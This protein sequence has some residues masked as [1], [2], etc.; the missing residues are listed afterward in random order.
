MASHSNFFYNIDY[1]KSPFLF[2]FSSKEYV[3]TK[4]GFLTSLWVYAI[5]LYFFFNSNMIMRRNPEIQDLLLANPSPL[6]SL[7]NQNFAPVIIIKNQ[8]LVPIIID[9]SY[10]TIKITQN[11][12][13]SSDGSLTEDLRIIHLC[14]NNDFNDNVPEYYYKGGYCFNSSLKISTLESDSEYLSIKLNLCDNVTSSKICQPLENIQN[15]LDGC[16]FYFFFY[17]NNFD[18]SDFLNPGKFNVQNI[19]QFIVNKDFIQY[20]IYGLMEVDLLENN[21]YFYD[22]E[23]KTKYF[24]QDASQFASEF[25]YYSE[26]KAHTLIALD[27]YPSFTKRVIVRRYQKF[28]ELLSSIGGL[29]SVLHIFGSLFVNFLKKITLLEGI[30]NNNYQIKEKNE[31]NELNKS[32]LNDFPLNINRYLNK[33]KHVNKKNLF[34]KSYFSENQDNIKEFEFELPKIEIVSSE[35]K[36]IKIPHATTNKT[37]FLEKKNKSTKLDLQIKNF[38][39]TVRKNDQNLNK[40]KYFNNKEKIRKNTFPLPKMKKKRKEKRKKLKKI[41]FSLTNMKEKWKKIINPI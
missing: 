34:I 13:N 29:A 38:N 15:F 5:L 28:I 21:N 37:E 2:N 20:C 18:L 32:K 11:F 9:P 23:V 6:I 39:S 10:F 41:I 22:E 19:K 40:E 7:N 12:Y 26:K 33:N 24:Q 17:D 14:N 8:D 27:I 30:I 16:Y 25:Y 3:S 31:K 35:E 36:F 4:L 1:F